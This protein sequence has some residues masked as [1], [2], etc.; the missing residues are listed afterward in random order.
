MYLYAYHFLSF[1]FFLEYQISLLRSIS[2]CL[3]QVLPTLF[4]NECPDGTLL[5]FVCSYSWRKFS[6]LIDYWCEKYFLSAHWRYVSTFR[7]PLSHMCGQLPS[8]MAPLDPICFTLAALQI[9]LCWAVRTRTI[10]TQGWVCFVCLFCLSF[11]GFL[12][13]VLWFYPFQIFFLHYAFKWFLCHTLFYTSRTDI[14]H[15]LKLL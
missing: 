15:L 6:L 7:F 13:F 11:V 9:S 3:R 12:E 5:D 10:C 8:A 14:T 2:F 4:C 1:L